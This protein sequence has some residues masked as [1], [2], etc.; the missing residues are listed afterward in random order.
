[1]INIVT[2]I[3]AGSLRKLFYKIKIEL[4]LL[5]LFFYGIYYGRLLV[6]ECSIANVF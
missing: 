2:T 4:S 3:S 1:M 5:I 6:G